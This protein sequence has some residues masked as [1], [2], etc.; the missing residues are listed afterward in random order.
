VEPVE[1]RLAKLIHWRKLPLAIFASG[2]ALGKLVQPA[3]SVVFAWPI[4]GGVPSPQG[5]ALEAAEPV[6][7]AGQS[8]TP[9]DFFQ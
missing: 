6:K 8:R 1:A 9:G 4:S 7:N 5:R 2:E 3:K